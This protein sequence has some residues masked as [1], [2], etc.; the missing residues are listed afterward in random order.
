MVSAAL[1]LTA[2][3]VSLQRLAELRYANHNRRQALQNGALEYGAAHYPLFFILHGC[4]FAGW[5]VE[6]VMSGNLFAYWPL[7]LIL[8][9]AAQILRY[10]C[11]ATLGSCWNTRIL[12]MPGACRVCKGPYRFLKHPN[13]VAVA[14]ELAVLPLAFGAYWTALAATAANALLVLGVRLPAERKALLLLAEAAT[15]LE[16]FSL[17]MQNKKST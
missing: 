2:V 5:L 1:I 17:K 8:F 14:V 16:D 12:V 7:C 4:W 3:W 10:W 13:Y 6:G 15:S 9:L 11:I